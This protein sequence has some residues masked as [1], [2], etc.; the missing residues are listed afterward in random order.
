MPLRPLLLAAA[1][2]VAAPAAAA[3]AEPDAGAPGSARVAVRVDSPAPGTRLEGQLH[4]AE[5]IGS[6]SADT[7]QGDRFDVMLVIDVSESTK[8]ASGTDLDGDGVVGIDPRFEL[9]PQ[10][11]YPPE[12]VSTDPQ[13]TVLHAEVQAARALLRSLDPRRVRVGVIS[14]AGEVDPTTLKRRRREPNGLRKSTCRR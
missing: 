14:F 7:D 1:L 10:G 2:W 13:D 9:V 6:A 8:N 11:T 4:Q 5:V 12:V 3:P